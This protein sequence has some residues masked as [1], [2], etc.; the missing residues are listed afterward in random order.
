M[1]YKVVLLTCIV[2][3][4]ACSSEDNASIES[5]ELINYE[6]VIADTIGIEIGDSNYVFGTI[7]DAAYLPDG[8][9]ILLDVLENIV[10]VFSPEG[11]FLFS[12][13]SEGNGPG[14][15]AEPV[16]LAVLDDGRLAV[17]DY[18][19]Q[20]LVF[21]DTLLNY[22]CELSGF[23]PTPPHGIEN[24]GGGSVVGMQSHYFIE[25]ET[26]YF[27]LRLGS[28]S[29]SIEPD[30]IY[31]SAYTVPENGRIELYFVE[32]CTDSRGRIYTAPT[33]YDEYSITC[34]NPEGDTLF[35][36]TEP[37]TRTEKTPEEIESEYLSYRYD[38]PGLDADDRR[39]I[40]SRWEPYPYRQAIK[41]IYAD[42]MDRIWV[43]SGRREGSSPL[44]EVYSSTGTH[45]CTVPTSFGPEA[46]NWKFV[47]G[48]STVLAFD[49]NPNDYSKVLLLN[50]T[51][52]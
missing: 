41:E 34:Y 50:I 6:L 52:N 19:H 30:L 32:F 3:A 38:M 29:N 20:K 10:S 18:M 40:T 14:E 25:G 15:F 21:C 12:F 2:L 24:G 17:C 22:S 5:V 43:L 9:I 11:E 23:N 48:D 44:F 39:A 33:S 51:Q 45:I 37:Y 27:G 35:Y 36:L 16:E 13:G 46:N 31:A 7:I 28:W 49:T 42:E 1:K 47:F 8:R 4:L 26:P